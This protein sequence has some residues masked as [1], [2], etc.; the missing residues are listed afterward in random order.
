L[1]V[2]ELD[3]IWQIP[4]EFGKNGEEEDNL[5]RKNLPIKGEAKAA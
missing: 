2:H 3:E 5:K 1:P 4:D